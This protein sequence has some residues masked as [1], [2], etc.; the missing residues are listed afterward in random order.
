MTNVELIG[1]ENVQTILRGLPAQINSKLTLAGIKKAVQ[2]IK[3]SAIANAP[4]RRNRTAKMKGPIYKAITI[5]NNDSKE[6][7]VLVSATKGRN[8]KYD[9]WYA[10][11]QEKGTKGF[12]KRKRSSGQIAVSLKSGTVYKRQQRTVGYGKKGTGLEAQ[13]FMER[14]FNVNQ[15]KYLRT[16]KPEI[17]KVVTRFVRKHNTKVLSHYAD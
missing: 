5:V 16:V 7:A 12:G 15:D 9:A 1:Y 3:N 17:A 2:P 11:F 13:K 4:R 14:A 6:P 8:A 10:H